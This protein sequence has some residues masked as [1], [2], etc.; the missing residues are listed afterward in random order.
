MFELKNLLL[1]Y[2]KSKFLK[3]FIGLKYMYIPIHVIINNVNDADIIYNNSRA[4]DLIILI[5]KSSAN[6]ILFYYSVIF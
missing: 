1:I 4:N 5:F 2:Y 3:Y 6:L